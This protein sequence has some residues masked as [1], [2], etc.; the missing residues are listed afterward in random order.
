MVKRAIELKQKDYYH[1]DIARV[2]HREF[3]LERVPAITNRSL[4]AG[5]GLRQRNQRDRYDTLAGVLPGIEWVNIVRSKD[6]H[7]LNITPSASC[8]AN[9]NGGRLRREP[10]A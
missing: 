6:K 2:I 4:L 1:Y 7:Y 5:K 10:P 8:V 3:K 9:W